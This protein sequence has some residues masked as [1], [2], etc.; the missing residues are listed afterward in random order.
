ML[1]GLDPEWIIV[2]LA[3]EGTVRVGTP[4]SGGY[5]IEVAIRFSKVF[6]FRK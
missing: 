4:G 2:N 3:L 6:L 1:C 5:I